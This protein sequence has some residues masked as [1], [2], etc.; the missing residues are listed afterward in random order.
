[1][2][3]ILLVG[4]SP[5]VLLACSKED[6]IAPTASILS[7]QDGETYYADQKILFEGLITDDAVSPN[8]LSVV[9]KSD[10][11]GE[12]DWAN[13]PDSKGRISGHGYLTE[14]EHSISLTATDTDG[15]IG[16]DSLL[17]TIGPNNSAPSCAITAPPEGTATNEGDAVTLVAE[18]DDVDVG[19]LELSLSWASDLAGD[20]GTSTA[21]L[22]G[23]SSLEVE[24]LALGT[25]TV[26]LTVA[27]EMGLECQA[28]IQH[29]IGQAPRLTWQAPEAEAVLSSEN[30]GY[31]VLLVEDDAHA[32]EDLE[33]LW[34]SSLDGSLDPDPIDS[35]GLS[36]R[37]LEDLSLGTHVLTAIATNPDDLSGTA[38]LTLTV[39]GVPEAPSVVI[40]PDPSTTT[41][42]LT[43][44]VTEGA[45]PEGD[46]QTFLYQWSKDG[47]LDSSVTGEVVP[48]TA[49]A[50]GEEWTVRVTPN[51]G[52]GNGPLGLA[53]IVVANTV[54]TVNTVSIN[55][56]TPTVSDTLVCSYGY[57]DY[58]SDADASTI[59]WTVDST[60]VGTG[61]TLAAGSASKNEAVSC[62][63]T[64]NDGTDTG[65]A[66]SDTVTVINTAPVVSGVSISPTSPT[67]S[68]ALT[69]SYSFSDDDSDADSSSVTWTVGSTTLG[70]GSTLSA[71][72]ATKG[73]SVVC[74]VEADDGEETGNTATSNVAIENSAPTAPV[75]SISPS[76]PVALVDDLI[77][78]IDTAST[79]DDGDAITYTVLWEVE[80]ASWTGSTSTTSQSGDTVSASDLVYDEEWTCSIT[81]D[82]GTVAGT[83]GE[84][85][86]TVVCQD[87]DGDGY[88]DSSCGGTDCDDTDDTLTPEDAD[89]DG[90]ST[91]DGDCNDQSPKFNPAGT[92][93]LIADRDCDGTPSGAGSRSRRL[94]TDR[95]KPC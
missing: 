68:D 34:E 29:K 73:E 43:A 70:T 42:D 71:G 21:D 9:W 46:A 32:A 7:P 17:L 45:D 26:T 44:V 47:V 12:L 55:P 58:D 74:T 80:G 48:N 3:S 57:V 50:K 19:P 40:L 95:R 88:S 60:V 67:V 52:Y 20:L 24:G 1:M 64:P 39:N 25:H 83:A 14:G 33:V 38:S 16:R 27:D 89:G 22:N 37:T 79:D 28:Q 8:E 41:N 91:C 13:E 10:I 90:Y 59:E 30:P 76:A 82:D 51:D 15:L 85:S 35:E 84:D 53:S 61:D 63:V 36:Q 2:R 5:L 69:C 62:T 77:C 31:A 54:P 93:G 81:P 86:V 4:L 75:V 6:P 49:T 87:A 56:T 11:D 18:V 65:T 78:I 94:Q 92:D 66:V 23:L 72:S